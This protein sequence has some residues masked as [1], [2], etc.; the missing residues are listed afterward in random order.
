MDQRRYNQLQP[1]IRRQ[2]DLGIGQ[3]LEDHERDSLADYL[4]GFVDDPEVLVE[5]FNPSRRHYFATLLAKAFNVDTPSSD[6]G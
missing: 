2:L 5:G 4:A 3:H 6:G 1:A